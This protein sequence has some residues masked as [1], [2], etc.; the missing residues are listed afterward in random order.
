MPPQKK[1]RSIIGCIMHRAKQAAGPG[2][3]SR[4]AFARGTASALA[5][6]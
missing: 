5:L 3:Q 1:L 2:E 6:A 4:S